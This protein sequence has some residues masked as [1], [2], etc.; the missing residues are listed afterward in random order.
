MAEATN[1]AHLAR[2][3]A[4]IALAVNVCAR[5]VALNAA[6]DQPPRRNPEPLRVQRARSS[7]QGGGVPC[8]EPRRA[9]RRCQGGC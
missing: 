1:S 5:Q 2:L 4:S 7:D 9:N 8:R 3:R 6:K